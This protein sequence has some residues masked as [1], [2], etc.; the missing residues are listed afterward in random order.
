MVT[1]ELHR[2]LAPKHDDFATLVAIFSSM[3]CVIG[4]AKAGLSRVHLAKLSKNTTSLGPGI[5][6]FGS[7]STWTCTRPWGCSTQPARTQESRQEQTMKTRTDERG[8]KERRKEDERD[9]R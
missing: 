7:Y 2:T 4:S 6:P 3:I 5:I 9:G 8:A 1:N